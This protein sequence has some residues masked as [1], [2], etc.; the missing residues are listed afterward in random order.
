M[1]DEKKTAGELAREARAA[2]TL[3]DAAQRRE[4]LS[5]NDDPSVGRISDSIA[6]A[7]DPTRR[8]RY[9]VEHHRNTN[10]YRLAK[11]VAKERLGA[12]REALVQARAAGVTLDTADRKELIAQAG[13]GKIPARMATK[14]RDAAGQMLDDDSGDMNPVDQIRQAAIVA[15]ADSAPTSFTPPGND[16]EREVQ[17]ILAGIPRAT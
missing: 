16:D 3:A 9:A 7:E 4:V 1:A 5:A 6:E 13:A 10:A 15:A 11:D 17:D 14:L 8:S 2:A 12:V